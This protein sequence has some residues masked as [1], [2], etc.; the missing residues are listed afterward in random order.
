LDNEQKRSKSVFGVDFEVTKSRMNNYC[1]KKPSDVILQ[2]WF[3]VFKIP[4]IELWGVKL[5]QDVVNNHQNRWK[6]NFKYGLKFRIKE[7]RR[8]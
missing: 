1:K 8:C 2:G 7:N 5:E 6:Q 3:V 4:H